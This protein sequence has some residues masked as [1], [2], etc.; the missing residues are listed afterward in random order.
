MRGMNEARQIALPP[1][2]IILALHTLQLS[3]VQLS[4][5]AGEQHC[6]VDDKERHD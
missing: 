3:D 1:M 4:V 2:Y 6:A 5:L